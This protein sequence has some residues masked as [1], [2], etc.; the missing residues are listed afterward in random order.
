MSPL[1]SHQRD[2]VLEPSAADRTAYGHVGCLIDGSDAT[3]ATIDAAARL[4][5]ADGT[6]SVLFCDASIACP[7][8][9][10]M[11]EVW[12]P[13]L[14]EL[15]ESTRAW[16]SSVVRSVHDAEAVVLEGAPSWSLV[17]WARAARPDLLVVGEPG[18]RLGL[19]GGI[20]VERL[21]RDL[22]CP[23]LVLPGPAAANGRRRARRFT[24]RPRVAVL[25]S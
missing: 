4:R 14:E 15:R 2:G 22:P 11:G 9:F 20:R 13:D 17:A 24:G 25:E 6:L 12:V 16:L 8:I 21:A 10:P 1:G 19:F 18:R 23:L 3:A 5:G 7:L